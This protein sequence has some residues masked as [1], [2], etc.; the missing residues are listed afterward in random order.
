M[1]RWRPIPGWP[2]Y[3]VSLDGRVRS[4]D[5]VVV[6]RRGVRRHLRGVELAPTRGQVYLSCWG[7]GRTIT[8]SWLVGAAWG[9]A[10]VR[11]P[12]PAPRRERPSRRHPTTRCTP[13]KVLENA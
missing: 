11:V 12:E 2:G 6:D 4:L 1:T 9:H 7:Y 5:R 8:V 13:T 10:L 3:E